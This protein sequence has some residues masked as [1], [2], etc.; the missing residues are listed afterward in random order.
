MPLK[1]FS[2]N[3][4]GLISSRY[5]KKDNNHNVLEIIGTCGE[6]SAWITSIIVYKLSLAFL[7]CNKINF[8][9]YKTY[10]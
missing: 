1:F 7:T 5:P 6:G 3:N 8:L 4:I 2:C 10:D 9:N